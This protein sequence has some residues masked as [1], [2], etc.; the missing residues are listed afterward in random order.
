MV[1]RFH[2]TSNEIVDTDDSDLANFGKVANALR[3]PN[4]VLLVPT[5]GFTYPTDGDGEANTVLIP[6]RSIAYIEKV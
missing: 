5:G 4:A 3:D 2:L 6:V 1:T